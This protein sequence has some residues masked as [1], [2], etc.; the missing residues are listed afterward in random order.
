M[1]LSAPVHINML[2]FFKTGT[3]DC[4]KLGQSKAWVLSNFPDPDSGWDEDMQSG[5]FDIWTYG[6]FELHFEKGKLF[7]IF[8]D[9]LENLHGGEDIELEPWIFSEP[10]RLNLS[11]VLKAINEQAMSYKKQ[12]DNLGVVLRL[13]SGVEFTFENIDDVDGLSENEFSLTSFGLVAENF[14]RWRI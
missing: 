1:K 5:G 6:N 14:R 8:S 13:E 2:Q 4:L 11:E 7:L 12:S 10:H 3:F 9:N